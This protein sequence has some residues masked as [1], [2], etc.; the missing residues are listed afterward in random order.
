MTAPFY[1]ISYSRSQLYFAE[2]VAVELER[3]SVDVWFD[4]QQLKT[5]EDWASEIKR[6]LDECA[7]VVL[8]VSQRSLA[9][10]YVE[11]EWKAALDAGKPVY[12]L[13]FEP[14]ELTDERLKAC[15]AVDGR[16]RFKPAVRQLA[17]AINQ[18]EMPQ[19]GARFRTIRPPKRLARVLAA[20]DDGLMRFPTK[21]SPGVLL[22]TLS[23]LGISA[24]LFLSM[25]MAWML[26]GI[27]FSLWLAVLAG[28]GVLASS[29]YVRRKLVGEP[30]RFFVLVSFFGAL[31]MLA[32][33]SSYPNQQRTMLILAAIVAASTA[34]FVLAYIFRGGDVLRWTLTGF[35]GERRRRRYHGGRWLKR[36]GTG[37][38]RVSYRVLHSRGDEKF[39]VRLNKAM[40]K[41][42]HV[43]ASDDADRDDTFDFFLVSNV[44]VWDDVQAAV[45]AHP[46]LIAAAMTS[47]KLPDDVYQK[48][49]RFQYLDARMDAKR[50]FEVMAASLTEKEVQSNSL[51]ASLETTPANLD[52]TVIPGRVQGGLGTLRL[53]AL[54]GLL[55]PV[56]VVLQIIVNRAAMAG[57]D[58][59]LPT[60]VLSLAAGLGF[61]LFCFGLEHL[62][63]SRQVTARNFMLIYAVGMIVYSAVSAAIGG[64]QILGDE[65]AQGPWAFAASIAV[66]FLTSAG[67]FAWLPAVQPRALSFAGVR[68]EGGRIARDV[69]I[70][71]A[72]ATYA[73]FAI[74]P[75]LIFGGL[76]AVQAAGSTT[77]L[78]GSAPVFYSY[79]TSGNLTVRFPAGI[80]YVRL[81]AGK[82][83]ATRTDIDPVVLAA[84]QQFV[85]QVSPNLGE[86]FMPTYAGYAVDDIG[87]LTLIGGQ[88]VVQASEDSADYSRQRLQEQIPGLTALDANLEYEPEY[89][90]GSESGAVPGALAFLSLTDNN[91]VPMKIN[92]AA[93]DTATAHHMIYVV[94][95]DT[96][97]MQGLVEQL[98]LLLQP[99]R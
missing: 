18:G 60:L 9:S 2:S 78:G 1:F 14:A 76:G 66:L 73:T 87:A 48:I 38:Y 3:M 64:V 50:R 71:S 41:Y 15:P 28:Y 43:P 37:N 81:D 40:Q 86:T 47:V 27:A 23:L 72:I 85:D 95:T 11:L 93:I 58:L 32:M 21:L 55:A 62:A 8:I 25:L 89:T 30:P 10:K 92:F 59:S 33:F 79:I 57:T 91:G 4:L 22:I 17:R 70:I 49:G 35:G 53:Y 29:H 46:R 97:P 77:G 67:L 88:F 24:A 51:S 12:L 94:N 80:K 63:R 90:F 26:F 19:E 5:G 69:V 74:F 20:D 45:E 39:A 36:A 75:V 44:T 56:L 82:L 68:A 16:G 42:K 34:V 65:L 7:G 6:G 98:F 83:D 96:A 52:L 99:A 84:V 54:V 31:A 13:Y 61:A